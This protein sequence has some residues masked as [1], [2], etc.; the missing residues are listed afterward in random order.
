M[1]SSI[2]IELE[3]YLNNSCLFINGTLTRA[4]SSCKAGTIRNG[5][6]RVLNTSQNRSL[7]IRCMISAWGVNFLL[8]IQSAYFKPRQQGVRVD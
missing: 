1:I 3:K 5:N 8:G 2:P 7:T 6:K 4:T